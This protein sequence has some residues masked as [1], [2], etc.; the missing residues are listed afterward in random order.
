MKIP[1]TR[2]LDLS[3]TFQF[4]NSAKS[5]RWEWSYNSEK[6]QLVAEMDGIQIAK[7]FLPWHYEWTTDQKLEPIE[8]FHLGVVAIRS[9]HAVCGYFHG[10]NLLDHKVIR[11]YMVRKKQGKSQIKHLKTKGKSRAGSRIRLEE[12][13]RFF[14]EINER[15]NYYQT[16]FPIHRWGIACSKTLWPYFFQSDTPPPFEQQSKS[17]LPLPVHFNQASYEELQDLSKVLFSSHLLVSEI[18]EKLVENLEFKEIPKNDQ[19]DNW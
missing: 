2:S 17:L 4:I 3:Q 15:L 14:E 5:S 1:N 19:E 10:E 18:G 16:A 6:H 13:E 7:L 12:T 8:D 11:A 9:G